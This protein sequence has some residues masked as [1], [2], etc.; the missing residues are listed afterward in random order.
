MNFCHNCGV[1]LNNNPKFCPECGAKLN[2]T[3]DA[4][5]E[6]LDEPKT[7]ETEVK[8]SEVSVKSKGGYL[9]PILG[10]LIFILIFGSRALWTSY[11]NNDVSMVSTKDFKELLLDKNWM[12]ASYS[13][14]TISSNNDA[15]S[16]STLESQLNEMID[17]P[18]SYIRYKR[19]PKCQS[20][21]LIKYDQ[22][23][24]DELGES[25]YGIYVFEVS[26]KKGKHRLYHESNKIHSIGIGSYI[27]NS[28]EMDE[29][30]EEGLITQI[31]EKTLKISV[32]N[33]IKTLDGAFLE[34][35][36]DLVYRAIE[37]GDESV[38]VKA[39]HEITDDWMI[40]DCNEFMITPKIG[41]ETYNELKAIDESYDFDLDLSDAEFDYDEL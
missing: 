28:W 13:N 40:I 3:S 6:A 26:E 33:Y 8:K 19:A 2:Q 11:K 9:Y 31:N 34:I 1:K 22:S 30:N 12:L 35:D 32:H 36:Y 20:N 10:G 7:K 18:A 29:Y 17:N 15:W 27:D 39:N 24:D 25:N 21:R 16:Q 38:M 14:L 37:D 23:F 5:E 41:T 4:Q